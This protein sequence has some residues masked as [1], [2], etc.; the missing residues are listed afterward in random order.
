M[1]YGVGSMTTQTEKLLDDVA[2]IFHKHGHSYV[3][4]NKYQCRALASIVVEKCRTPNP[5]A[6]GDTAKL[7]FFDVYDE[8][9][10]LEQEIDEKMIEFGLSWE[11]NGYDSYDSSIE[12][13]G[14]APESRL[15]KEAQD[16]LSSMGFG[17]AWLNHKD[18]METYYGFPIP[19]LNV[20]AKESRKK[21][22]PHRQYRH[23]PNLSALDSDEAVGS[24]H[25]SIIEAIQ[26]YGSNSNQIAKAAIQAVKGILEGKK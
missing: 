13:Y 8:H 17:R 21:S 18:N 2:D 6:E 11:R 9:I 4:F 26:T 5:S 25:K 20:E 14:V 19:S 7:S 23:E 16:Y 12:F 3:P 24:V 15:S 22:S 1:V 10:A